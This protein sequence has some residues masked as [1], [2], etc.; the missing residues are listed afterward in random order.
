[1]HDKLI[2]VIQRWRMHMSEASHL[3]T[4][5]FLLLAVVQIWC[6]NMHQWLAVDWPCARGRV[7]RRGLWMET[8][9]FSAPP[10]LGLL[11]HRQLG[12]SRS[13]LTSSA[14]PLTS[15]TPLIAD[16]LSGRTINGHVHIQEKKN[17][18][19]LF[20]SA[21]QNPSQLFSWHVEGKRFFSLWWGNKMSNPRR[22]KAAT[23]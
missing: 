21:I 15:N 18:G 8:R 3:Q 4:K 9:C 14:G 5:C 1:M 19:V 13:S 20:S 11:L 17:P 22:V 2:D 16:K 7:L 10:K 23:C 6:Q 12:V